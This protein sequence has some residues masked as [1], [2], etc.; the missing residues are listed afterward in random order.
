MNGFAEG[1]PDTGE[2]TQSGADRPMVPR[3][4]GGAG[5]PCAMSIL[6]IEHSAD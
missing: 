1:M 2:R 4:P 5:K 3:I 6:T